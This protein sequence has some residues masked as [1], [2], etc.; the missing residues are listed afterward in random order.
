MN[1]WNGLLR[2]MRFWEYCYVLKIKEVNLKTIKCM[3]QNT[4]KK[5]EQN[6]KVKF[7]TTDKIEVV[8]MKANLHYL[9]VASKNW[10]WRR[11]TKVINQNL[12]S[13]KHWNFKNI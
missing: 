6:H 5:K 3:N 7:L 10:I 8:G 1:F 9:P 2:G 11:M 12:R 4:K 13:Y